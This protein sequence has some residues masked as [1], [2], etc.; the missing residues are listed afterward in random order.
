[1][2]SDKKLQSIQKTLGP[3]AIGELEGHNDDGLTYTVTQSAG[4]IKEAEDK[5]E[6]N[7]KYI[8]LKASL[9]ACSEGVREVKK[10]QNAKIQYALH[11]LEEKGKQ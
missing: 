1:M 11:L 3:D 5:L 2:L 6:S 10:F 4:A 8:E 9:K 7:E